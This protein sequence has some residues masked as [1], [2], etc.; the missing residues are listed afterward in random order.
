M[1]NIYLSI[2]PVVNAVLL[3]PLSDPYQSRTQGSHEYSFQYQS[4]NGLSYRYNSIPLIMI[5][6]A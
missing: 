4:G 5:D 2:Y 1:I 6:E 3:K